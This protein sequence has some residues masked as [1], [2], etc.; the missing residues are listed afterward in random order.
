L[1]CQAASAATP[2]ALSEWFYPLLGVLV[3]LNGSL[4]LWFLLLRRKERERT[5]RLEREVAE[6]EQSEQ[7]LIESRKRFLQVVREIPVMFVAFDEEN[8]ILIWNRECE[9]GTGYSAKEM[10][11][12]PNA[13]ALLYPDEEE[14]QRVFAA[15]EKHQGD[16]HDLELRL[17]CKD[18]SQ[19][20]ISWTNVSDASPIPGWATWGVGYDVTEL[21][22]NRARLERLAF[23]DPLTGLANRLMLSKYLAQAMSSARRH[24]QRMAVCYLDLDSFKPINDN[25]GHN[26][27][28]QL[29]K[30][31]AERIRANIRT[32]DAA[33]RLGG[34]EFVILL[35]DLGGIPECSDTLS[36]LL[37]ILAEPYSIGGVLHRVS[38]SIGVTL[39]P[40]DDVD[41][42]ALLRH[43]DQAMYS[44][45]QLGR[46]RYHF[47]DLAQDQQAH[48]R[49]EQLARMDQALGMHELELY[50][51]P[52]VDMRRGLV[53]GVEAL[54]RWRHPEIGLIMPG[55]FLPNLENHP[56]ALK[57]DMQVCELA[58]RQI[59]AW[60]SEGIELRVSI[61]LSAQTLQQ[62]DLLARLDELFSQYPGVSPASIALEVLESTALSDV[63]QVARL[64]EECSR[65]GIVFAID[66]F[67]TGYSSLTYFRR[68]PAQVLKIDRAFVRDML[69][70]EEDMHIVQG[71]VGLARTFDRRVIAEGVESPMHGAVLLQMGCD[72]AQG[73]GL[74]E[75]MPADEVPAWLR[76]F[77]PHP[78]WS[79]SAMLRLSREDMALLTAETEHRRW[80]D[81]VKLWLVE[82]GEASE[83]PQLDHTKCGFGRWYHGARG[84]RYNQLEAFHKLGE[85]HLRVH[86]L[87]DHLLQAD[88][89]APEQLTQGLEELDQARDELLGWLHKLQVD[90]M[91]GQD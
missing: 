91:E 31:V 10:I 60:R 20:L 52:Q 45:K 47:F 66:D 57:L 13:M 1:W 18:G 16:F 89:M 24:G 62:R 51:Q 38:A 76:D 15:I 5:L 34:D 11:G 39:Y 23:Y 54:V 40:E 88:S 33:A 19:R 30:Q 77:S 36:R 25:Y 78:M 35:G 49:S 90:V 26:V 56:L 81:Q 72:L 6:R 2:T 53:Y 48:Q 86:Q 79:R 17:R 27:G 75:P 64:I 63:D 74:A 22:E 83:R 85:V 3:G 71:I 44:A 70:D 8:R 7:E 43:A 41:G 82:G 69:E 73:Y 32:E 21:H 4:A 9:R 80:I 12:N 28:D 59:Q 42:D 55:D 29:L 58:F 67:G 87:A 84:S 14:R 65:R 68:L 61:N 37:S 46:N 50:Y